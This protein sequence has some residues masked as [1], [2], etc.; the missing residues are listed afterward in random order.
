MPARTDADAT[1]IGGYR[2]R[3]SAWFARRGRRL[4]FRER[5]EPWAV[6]VS[7]VMAQQTQ[8]RWRTWILVVNV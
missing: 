7:E 8:V 6:M 5:R 2:A 3:L 1:L 4:A